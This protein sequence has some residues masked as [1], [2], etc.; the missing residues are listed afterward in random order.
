V[1]TVTVDVAIN[2]AATITNVASAS[3]G[4]ELNAVND[5]AT[6]IT[7]VT[8]PPDFTLSFTP[9][10]ITINAG[11]QASYAMTVTSLIDA[12]ANTITFTASGLPPRTSFVF[13]PSV[14]TPGANAATSSFVVSTSGGDAFVA[15]NSERNRVPLYGL[16]LPLAGLVLSGFG[17]R[18]GRSKKGWFL[19]VVIP[20]CVGLGLYGCVGAAGNFKN[21]STPPGTY[22][23]TITATSGTL[24]H[25]APVTLIVQP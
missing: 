16:L 13:H 5:V 22:T 23:V 9:T 14:A 11:Q 8:S 7:T 15:S 20:V 10:T 4:G 6:N 25:S 1:I 12:F 17:F 24:Q 18:K 21:L 2:E 3:G 19:V